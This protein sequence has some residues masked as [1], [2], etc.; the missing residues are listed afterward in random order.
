[1]ERKTSTSTG[2][3]MLKRDRRVPPGVLDS[4]RRTICNK[5][6]G[7]IVTW[8]KYGYETNGAEAVAT[9]S[10]LPGGGPPLHYHTTY[11]ERFQP[12]DGDLSVMLG[13]GAKQTHIVVKPGEAVDVPIGAKHRFFNESDKEVKFRGWVLPAHAGFEQSL[14]ILYGLNNDGLGDPKTGLPS[15][16]LHTAVVA[17]LGDMRFPGLAGGMTNYFVKILAWYA[18]W[19]GVEEEL[20]KKYWD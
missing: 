12:I 11:A 13:D 4:A 10:C 20:L 5:R 1:M 14:Y 15:S 18:R 2:N 9:A 16:L 6:F 8:D 3:T 17:N 7:E 19:T